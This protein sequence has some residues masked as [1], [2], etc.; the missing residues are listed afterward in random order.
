MD[1][2]FAFGTCANVAG[3][4][5]VCTDYASVAI[6]AMPISPYE[7]QEREARNKIV[8][9]NNERH[10][11]LLRELAHKVSSITSKYQLWVL[12]LD[13]QSYTNSDLH[14]VVYTTKAQDPFML[15]QKKYVEPEDDLWLDKYELTSESEEPLLPEHLENTVL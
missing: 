4:D 2:T 13:Y 10:I 5:S 1:C 14:V 9:Q 6:G 7:Q 12:D 15:A 11:E 8:Q 3:V